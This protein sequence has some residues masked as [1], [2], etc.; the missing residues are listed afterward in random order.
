[1]PLLQVLL[2]NDVLDVERD[3]GCRFLRQMA[4]LAPI[5]GTFSHECT[6]GGVHAMPGARTRKRRAFDWII[7]ITSIASTK[8]L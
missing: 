8:S 3:E 2:G 7:E 5:D 4:V 6:S 1:M